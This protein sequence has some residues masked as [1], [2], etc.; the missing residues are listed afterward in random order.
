MKNSNKIFK[1][2]IAVVCLTMTACAFSSCDADIHNSII[3]L[4]ENN[5]LLF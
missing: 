3:N 4:M 1:K 5:I 2:V